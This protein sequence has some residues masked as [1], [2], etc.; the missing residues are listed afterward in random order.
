MAM[1]DRHPD[2]QQLAEYFE[3]VLPPAN[4]DEMERHL[5]D[6]DECREQVVQAMS[7]AAIKAKEPQGLSR[8]LPF[9]LGRWV[10]GAAAALAAAALLVVAIRIVRPQWLGLGPRERP[11]LQ[12][13]IAA[14]ADEPTRPFEGRLSG[15]FP[16]APPRPP[17][18]GPGDGRV[19]PELTIAAAD[20]ERMGGAAGAHLLGLAYL[21]TGRVDEAIET[22]SREANPSQQALNDL[23]VAL[24]TKAAREGGTRSYTEALVTADRALNG[25]H[26]RSPLFNKSIALLGLGRVAEARA[27]A[28]EYFARD[29]ASSWAE[30]LRQRLARAAS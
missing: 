16:Y 6:C 26:D 30:E 2:A 9:P 10:S 20:I 27:V 29:A 28:D 8:L 18:R 22:L 14:V 15:D 5:A 24:L 23:A 1:F 17:T 19:S 7:V 25:N 13:L 3:D 11:E 21:T 4:R 12:E